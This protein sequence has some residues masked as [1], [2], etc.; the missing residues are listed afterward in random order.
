MNV[1]CPELCPRQPACDVT[2]GGEADPHARGGTISRGTGVVLFHA[3]LAFHGTGGTIPPWA[4]TAL[5]GGYLGVDFFFVLSGF[6]IHLHAASSGLAPGLF[7][8]RRLVRIVLPYWPVALAL[9]LTF[10]VQTREFWKVFERHERFA[11]SGAGRGSPVT[12]RSVRGHNRRKTRRSSCLAL[13]SSSCRFIS[14]TSTS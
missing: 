1:G 4:R 6:I 14:G 8:L 13:H 3:L 5:S 2:M 10:L 7:L 11:H 12:G 9:A